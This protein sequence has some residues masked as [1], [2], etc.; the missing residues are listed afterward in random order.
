[1]A[2]SGIILAGGF[3][4][5]LGQ[6]KGLLQLGG[7]PLIKHVLDSMQSVVDEKILVVGLGAQAE[8][9]VKIV[10]PGCRVLVDSAELHGPLAGALTGFKAASEEYSLLLPCD[11][12]FVS[13]EVLSLLAELC[14]N[15][16]AAI[17]RWPNCYIEPL[18]AVYRTIP[19]AEATAKALCTGEVNMQAMVNKLLGIRYVSTLVIEQLDNGL[20]TF[21]NINTPL[22]LRK[23]ETMLSQ[24][25]GGK[26]QKR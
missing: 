12:P 26:R 15:R 13:P 22:D 10:G 3:S 11:T 18:Q 21:F 5:R 7:K 2:T 6:D 25:R 24:C 16:N 8:K 9:Y 17:P 14:V 23:A 20:R 4:S 19:A 1:V